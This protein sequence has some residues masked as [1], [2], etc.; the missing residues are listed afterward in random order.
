MEPPQ[1]HMNHPLPSWVPGRGPPKWEGVDIP[2][3]TRKEAV[4]RFK[5][6]EPD[7]ELVKILTAEVGD[8]D[9]GL[10]ALVDIVRER[11]RARLL[12]GSHLSAYLGN[13]MQPHPSGAFHDTSISNVD[14][15]SDDFRMYHFKVSKSFPPLASYR[16]NNQPGCES[17]W[18]E[19]AGEDVHEAKGARLGAMPIRARGGEGE[20]EGSVPVQL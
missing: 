19:L 4:E 16:E 9:E 11:E 15:T 18:D 20:A 6:C 14:T 5:N 8:E 12:E 7:P 3:R 17:N 1:A 2:E 10:Q 13:A